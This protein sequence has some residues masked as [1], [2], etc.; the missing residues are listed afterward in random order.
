M[1]MS[2]RQMRKQ[3]ARG[4]EGGLL[5]LVHVMERGELSDFAGEAAAERCV[6]RIPARRTK[7]LERS[8]GGG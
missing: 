8:T 4:Q 3:G 5:R 2:R 6:P 1:W 7:A